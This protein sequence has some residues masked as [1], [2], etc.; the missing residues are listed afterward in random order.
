MEED[1]FRDWVGDAKRNI[2]LPMLSVPDTPVANVEIRL[3]EPT[4]VP[5]RVGSLGASLVSM[6]I[7]PTPD[8]LE[9]E[10]IMDE[11]I[12]LEVDKNLTGTVKVKKKGKFFVQ[13]SPTKSG[14]SD[15]SHTSPIPSEALQP[16]HRNSSGS[17][18]DASKTKAGSSPEPIKLKAH[19]EKRHVSLS[20]MRGKFG[21][22]KRKAAEALRAKDEGSGWEDDDEE[23]AE[24]WSDEDSPVKATSPARSLGEIARQISRPELTRQVSRRT[25]PKHYP[26]PPAPTPL[27]KMSKKERLAAAADR[28]KIEAELDA[29]RKREMFAKQQIFGSKSRSPGEGL[30]TGLFKRGGS[31]V[32]LVSPALPL[33]G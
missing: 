21:M 16:L 23:A 29:Q 7:A 4:P 30:L 32:D 17:S 24:D 11:P 8:E 9:E 27:R 19:K 13:S 31:M 22:E 26:P 5:S 1:N 6:R 25:P 12:Q 3:V 10:V 20:T 14:S 33:H 15:T 2:P 28:V 18:S